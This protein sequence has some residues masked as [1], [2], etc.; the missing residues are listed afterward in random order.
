[1]SNKISVYFESALGGI[2]DTS[3]WAL[4]TG[5]VTAPPLTSSAVHRTAIVLMD[6]TIR[7]TAL[8]AVV[9]EE[10]ELVLS[11]GDSQTGYFH[12]LTQMRPQLYLAAPLLKV[13]GVAW[14]RLH[15]DIVSRGPGHTALN[16]D[17]SLGFF[18]A[19]LI[20]TAGLTR[21]LCAISSPIANSAA[22][23]AI[24]FMFI[25]VRS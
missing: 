14:A 2:D 6:V 9:N 7:A 12:L 13:V 3:T 16:C 22:K 4:E 24:R 23:N 17:I 20:R 8:A 1:M 5:A 25:E 15:Q 18:R 21:S 11:A 19:V 10:E